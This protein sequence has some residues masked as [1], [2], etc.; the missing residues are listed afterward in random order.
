MNSEIEPARGL[1]TAN[2]ATVVWAIL[3]AATL[4]TAILGFEDS[5]RTAIFGVAILAIAFLK[6]EIVIFE[7]MEVRSAPMLL[8]AL[9]HSYV[10]VSFVTL[11]T[12]LLV[13]GN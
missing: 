10:A 9:A 5:S 3:L 11:M 6:V 12:L 8:K 13:A 4:L 2:R 7:Y 1:T